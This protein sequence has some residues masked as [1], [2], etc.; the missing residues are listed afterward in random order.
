M[1]VS[2]AKTSPRVERNQYLT[3]KHIKSYGDGNDYPQKVLEILASSGTGKICY[4]IYVKFVEGGG[5]ADQSFADFVV[6]EN[7]ERVSSLLTKFARDLRAFNGFACLVKYDF[8]GVITELYNIPFE[9]CRIEINQAK[10]Y[11]G[12]I[13][14]YDDWS[15]VTGKRYKQNE[16]KFLNRFKPEE[17]P[18][19][20]ILAGGVEQY[21]GQVYYFTADGDFEYPVCPFD[22]VVTDMLTEDSVST[23]KHRNAKYNFLPAGILVRKGKK[24]RT[25]DDGSLDPNDRYNAEQAYSANEIKKMQGDMN[26]SKIWVVDIDADEERP[27][28]IEFMAKNYDRQYEVTEKTIQENIGR[29]FMIPPILRGV[30]VGNGFASNLLNDAY[31][32]MSSATGDERRKLETAF[33]DLFEYHPAQFMDYTIKPLKYINN[34][35]AAPVT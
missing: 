18:A 10:D 32:F 17:V 6:N 16:V 4:E 28:F 14:V 11:T 35:N 21:E 12:R 22:P 7:G 29:M 34:E 31:N 1:R 13:A 15:G 2:A 20:M 33:K 26:A 5:F 23:V 25:L 27:E 8:L 9:Q 24:P 19:E 3:S 30:D